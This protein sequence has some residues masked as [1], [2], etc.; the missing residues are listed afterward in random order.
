LFVRHLRC[1]LCW[2]LGEGTRSFNHEDGKS[3][4]HRCSAVSINSLCLSYLPIR[5]RI[6]TTS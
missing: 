4:C 5:C 3:L 2:Q 6:T 1:Y